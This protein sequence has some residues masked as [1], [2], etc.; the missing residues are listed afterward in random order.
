M[1]PGREAAA[2]SNRLRELADWLA[3]LTAPSRMMD[4]L[5]ECEK[6]RWDA[7]ALGLGDAVRSHWRPIGSR[8][9]VIDHQDITRYH[10]PTYTFTIDSSIILVPE[11]WTW[12]ISNRAPDLKTGRAFIHNGELIFAGV[13]FRP[14]PRRQSE[15]ETAATPAIAMC[16]VSLRAHAQLI[17]P[18]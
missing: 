3:K 14:N 13:A 9:E 1:T 7:H 17:Y 6:R 18:V 12:Q 10:S 16:V 11:K 5:I 2:L 15:E 8:G 4:A